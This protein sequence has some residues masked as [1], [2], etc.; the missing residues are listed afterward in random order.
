MPRPGRVVFNAKL[1]AFARH[2][3]FQPRACAPYRA[4]TKG[5]TEAHPMPAGLHGD[6][7]RGVGHVKR[8]AIAG[9]SFAGWEAFEAGV[10][11]RS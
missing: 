11:M 3:G 4:R 1:L 9:R 6:P 5:K 7:E 10:P 8:N 2:W